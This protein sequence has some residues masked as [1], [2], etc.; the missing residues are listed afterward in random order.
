MIR[1]KY[2][3]AKYLCKY[4]LDIE[5]FEELNLNINDL[6]PARNIFVLDCLEGKKILKMINYD[7]DKLLFITYLL[8]YLKK[9]Y[10]GVLSINKFEDGKYLVERDGNKYVLLDLIEG[11]ECNLNNPLDLDAVSKSIA[12]LHIA[13]NGVLNDLSEDY[14]DKISLGNLKEKFEEGKNTLLNCKKLIDIKKYKNEFDDIFLENFDYNLECINKAMERF[15]KSNYDEMC[16]NED[17]ITVCHNDLAYHNMIVSE[18]KVSFID[19]DYANVDLR[20]LDIFNFAVKTLKKYAFDYDVY[21]KIIADYNS[22]SAISEEEM[23]VFKV[24][25]IYPSDFIT[26]SKNYYFS[27]K[28]WK[29]E[30]Y[31]SKLQNKV[32]YKKEKESL[33][34]YIG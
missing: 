17:I 28:D 6:W 3:D 15:E 32:L 20:I 14:R 27:L 29:Y 1:V 11:I 2:S 25:M 33:I 12:M 26:I 8:E 5:F 24:L 23:Q 22:I 4:D 34:N 10:E 21:E 18:G 31:L 13:G 9:G 30:S 7:E 19:F 16:K